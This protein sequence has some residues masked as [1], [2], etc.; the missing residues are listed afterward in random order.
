MQYFV[1]KPGQEVLSIILILPDL[2]IAS[3]VHQ[4]YV[5]SSYRISYLHL[6]KKIVIVIEEWPNVAGVREEDKQTCICI[7]RFFTNLIRCH[8]CAIV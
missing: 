2:L 8:N 5:P 1:A 6:L 4:S 7:D 3:M